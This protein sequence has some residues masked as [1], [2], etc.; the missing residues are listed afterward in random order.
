MSTSNKFPKNYDAT[1]QFNGLNGPICMPVDQVRTSSTHPIRAAAILN[2]N[3]DDDTK[4]R[5]RNC[6]VAGCKNGVVQGGVCVT[7]GAKRRLCR[8]P[9]CK[10]HSKNAG[11]CSKHGPPRKRCEHERCTNV[12]VRGGRCKSH[13]AWSKM[14]SFENCKKIAVNGGMCQQHH[15]NQNKKDEN[16]GQIA[17]AQSQV[18]AQGTLPSAEATDSAIQ[19]TPS[20]APMPPIVTGFLPGLDSTD[21]YAPLPIPLSLQLRGGNGDPTSIAA[22]Q[23]PYNPQ[24]YYDR[25]N[26]PYFNMNNPTIGFDANLAP[27][28][29]MHQYHQFQQTCVMN[30]PSTFHL[31]QK[32]PPQNYGGLNVAFAGQNPSMN[33][34]GNMNTSFNATS[35]E[36]TSTNASSMPAVGELNFFH[37]GR[38]HGVEKG[39]S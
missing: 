12:A 38:S 39:S 24:F 4:P 3:A 29:S 34:Y 6:S 23:G 26:L 31:S 15:T 35:L 36:F 10:K 7:H 19:T 13:G 25:S 14:C 30:N 22:T 11:L 28:P 21:S 8:F 17:R 16:L 32:I 5:R 1:E 33:P 27:N 2:V 9:G 37:H 18:E 20:L